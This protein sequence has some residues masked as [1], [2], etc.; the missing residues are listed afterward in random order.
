MNTLVQSVAR[1][2]MRA[3]RLV[4][5]VL[6]ALLGDLRWS[7]P[8]WM[9]RMATAARDAARRTSR[10]VAASRVANPG[11]FWMTVSSTLVLIVGAY[12]GTSWYLHRPQPRYLEISGTWPQPTP[13]RPD[14]RIDP[15]RI[16]FSGSAA[17]LGAVGK[18]VTSGITIE[19][20]LAGV[21]KWETDSDLT[22]TPAADWEVGRDYTA[23][24]APELFPPQVILKHYSY[25]FRSPAFA[26][27]ITDAQFYEDPIDPRDK[28]VVATITFTHPVDKADL[29]RRIALRMRVEPVKSFDSKDAR[30][31]GFTVTYDK[32]GGTAYIHSDPFPIP[33][34]EAAML[35]SIG[36]GVHS[37]RGG[38]GTTF[39]QARVV[40]IPGIATYFRIQYV[41]AA[42]VANERDEMERIATVLSTVPVRQEDLAGSI[43][44][45]TL[46]KD[47]PAIGDQKMV[48]DFRWSDPTQIVPEVMALATPVAIQW[49]PSELEFNPQQSFKFTADRGRFLMVTVRHGLTGFGDYRLTKDFSQV[50]AVPELPKELKIASAGSLLSLAGEK[51]ISIVSRGVG[52]MQIE[53]SRLLPGSVSHL[54]SQTNGTFTQPQFWSSQ[55]NLDDLSQVF[56]QVRPLAEDPSGRNQYSVFDF[57]PLLASGA[58]PRGLF[59]IKVS[60]WDPVNQQLLGGGPSDQRLILLTDLGVLVK[61][62]AD[63]SHD[64]FV[65]SIRTGMPLAYVE[66]E[67]LGRNGLP[68]LTNKSDANGRVTFPNLKDF[69]REKAPTV[70]VVEKD[71]DFSF[72]PYDRPDRQLDFSRF[73]TGG[74]YT[75]ERNETLQAYLF[76]D[77]GIYRPGDRI[78][79]GVV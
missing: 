3:V 5:T 63:G 35:M 59:S 78:H 18:I 38:P 22:F 39:A 64:V 8:P 66:V 1:A 50:I 21:W 33:N 20:A 75:D 57:A 56:T 37:T 25:K 73:D 16:E 65:Q 42:A 53:V 23:E 48:K 68:V 10:A 26:A 60:A 45:V 71:N 40:P 55:F 69:K 77:R 7:P 74:L 61:D 13:L 52:A 34:N 47:R 44:V 54:V 62:S 49:V 76:S 2:L 36:D 15:L 6:R 12:L 4:V 27:S 79:V 30:P 46:P 32:T 14:A 29:E 24:F 19:P 11:R 72:L 43:S 31:F 17:R 41:S 28:K 51:K 9:R 67:I 70:Y 58:L